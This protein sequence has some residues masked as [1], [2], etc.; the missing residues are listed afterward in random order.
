MAGAAI[1]GTVGDRHAVLMNNDTRDDRFERLGGLSLTLGSLGFVAVFLVLARQFHYPEVLERSAAEVLPALHAGGDG[2]RALW[3]VYAAL[4]LTLLVGG[5]ASM[6]LLE[7]GGGRGLAR[8][9]AVAAVLAAV[10]MMVGLVRWPSITWTLAERW[11]GAGVEERAVYAAVFDASNLYLG[12]IFGELLGETLMAVWFASLGAAFLATGRRVLGWAGLA[13]GVIGAIA[14][15]RLITPVV[16]P[17]AAANN[18][19]LPLWLLVLGVVML[20]GRVRT[21]ARLETGSAS[22]RSSA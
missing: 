1:A 17:I 13:M 7:R 3:F 18:S 22:A 16:D 11:A 4:P 21:T 6:P 9:G 10:A 14:V 5:L 12:N 19:L 20:R 15:L 2:L 8:L